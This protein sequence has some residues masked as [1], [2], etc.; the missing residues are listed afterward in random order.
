LLRELTH[1]LELGV[2][3]LGSF[4]VVGLVI[5]WAYLRWVLGLRFREILPKRSRADAGVAAR[6]TG[7]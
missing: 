3:E 7:P 5:Y 4:I 6:Q 2:A 1:R